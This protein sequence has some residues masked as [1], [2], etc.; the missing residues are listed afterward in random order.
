LEEDSAT[1]VRARKSLKDLRKQARLKK[2]PQPKGNRTSL[3]LRG[4][5]AEMPQG[6]TRG[7]YVIPESAEEDVP[8]TQSSKPKP[9]VR[10]SS[11]KGVARCHRTRKKCPNS[12]P[13]KPTSDPE[14]RSPD[15]RSLDS[16]KKGSSKKTPCLAVSAT[17]IG[18][19]A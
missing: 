13:N 6:V 3:R 18:S 14:R 11:T 19:T 9:K 1:Q 5:P 7:L 15:G 12:V 2:L 17:S 10:P 4:K 16:S 8:E